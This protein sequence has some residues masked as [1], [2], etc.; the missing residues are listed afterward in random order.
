M[1]TWRSPTNVT[2][3]DL[4][5]IEGAIGATEAGVV[6]AA[7][8]LVVASGPGALQRLAVGTNGQA[9]HVAGSMPA[10]GP[11]PPVDATEDLALPAWGVTEV[12][13]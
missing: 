2:A 7:G 10:W 11:L 8:D 6:Q 13:R 4:N 3:A 12:Y 1:T 9:L 5:R